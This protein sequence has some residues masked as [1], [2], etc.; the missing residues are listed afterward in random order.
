VVLQED[1]P[2]LLDP[3][4]RA[5]S[6]VIFQ[7]AR[8]LPRA[9]KPR[10]RLDCVVVGHLREEKDPR[11]VFG[12]LALL[13]PE[14]PIAIRHIGAPLDPGLGEAAGELQRRDPRYR[15]SGALSHGLTRAALKAAHVLIHPSIMEGGANVVAEAITAGTPVIASRISGN[16]GMLG[17]DSAGYFEPRDASGLARCL[18]Q[19]VGQAGYLEQLAAHCARRRVLFSPQAEARAVRRLVAA[20]VA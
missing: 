15:Y 16:V 17:G 12:A 10:G 18:V 13:P 20:L 3:P 8:L 11:T 1:A 19:A 5:K 4:W 14:A 2:S 9:R 7:S 6:E